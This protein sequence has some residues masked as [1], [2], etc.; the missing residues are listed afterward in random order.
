MLFDLQSPG[1]RRVIKVA[2]SVLAILFV[3]GFVGFGVGS[4]AG[5]GGI[6]D[7][8]SGGGGNGDDNPFEDQIEAAEARAEQNPKDPAAFAELVTLYYQAGNQNREVDE[9][10][11]QAPLTETGE[12]QLQQAVDAWAKYRKL[13]GKKLNTSTATF[14]VQAYAALA[15]AALA[16][17]LT[18]TSGGDA[19]DDANEA[20]A[21]WGEAAEAQR[22]LATARPSTAGYSTLAFFYYRSGQIAEGDQA[23]QQ[24]AAMAKGAEDQQIQQQLKQAKQ[25]GER[26]A[27]GIAQLRKAQQTAPSGGGEN[28]LGDDLGG[29]GGGGLGSGGL[30]SP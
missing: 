25:E 17:A 9:E 12:R 21:A 11:G 19:L 15:D 30:S 5:V 28:P 23:A 8:F 2:Y 1:R 3:V 6:A 29:F 27:S 13:S 20:L 18:A 10:T 26:L 24:A 14:A 4:E 16:G 7:V 22:V